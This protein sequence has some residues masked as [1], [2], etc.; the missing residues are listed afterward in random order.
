MKREEIIIQ[1]DEVKIRLIELQP[2]E[3][4]PWHFHTEVTDY[5]F[6]LS[7]EIEVKLKDP[8]ESVILTPGVRCQ[9]E[10]ARVHQVVNISAKEASRYLLVQGTGRYDFIKV[11]E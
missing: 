6:G 11:A 5:F 9:V 8:D 1:T 7:G 4:T 3:I 2:E 10:K